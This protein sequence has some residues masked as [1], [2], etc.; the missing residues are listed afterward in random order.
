MD[1]LATEAIAALRKNGMAESWIRDKE[2]S[3]KDASRLDVLRSFSNF[4]A[5]NM[6]AVC[7]QLGVSVEDMRATLR[8]LQ[9]I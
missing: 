2:Y 8:V 5:G 3:Y 4:D 9:K 7:D 1:F 6:K